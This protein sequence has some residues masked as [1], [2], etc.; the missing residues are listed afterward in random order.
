MNINC[1]NGLIFKKKIILWI[2][3]LQNDLFQNT[4]IFI[5]SI[6]SH[7]NIT[8]HDVLN[9]D[10]LIKL[11]EL[12]FTEPYTYLFIISKYAREYKT[13]V[14]VELKRKKLDSNK[15]RKIGAYLTMT[16]T[17]RMPLIMGM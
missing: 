3:N 10:C 8:I 2:S 1:K 9:N 15:I 17:L 16:V 11:Y 5:Q 4:S 14:C 12:S 13:T 6:S 7:K